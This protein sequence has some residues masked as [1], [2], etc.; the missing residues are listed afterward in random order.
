MKTAQKLGFVLLLFVVLGS[1]CRKECCNKYMNEGVITGYD[2]RECVCCGGLMIN[3][4]NNPTTYSGTYYLIDEMPP[5]SG[6]SAESKFPIYVS[7][8]WKKDD[9]NCYTNRIDISRIKIN[10]K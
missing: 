4:D 3:F 8:D 5:N 10:N 2:M 1:S 9:G 7:V 6:I